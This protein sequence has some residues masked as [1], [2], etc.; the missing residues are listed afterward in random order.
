MGFILMMKMVMKS[1]ARM[2]P[3]ELTYIEPFFK[4]LEPKAIPVVG[5]EWLFRFVCNDKKWSSVIG[6]ITDTS[7]NVL[8]L[9]AKY[10]VFKEM[11]KQHLI[12]FCREC[13]TVIG[14][15]L[16]DG[17]NRPWENICD[18]CISNFD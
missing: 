16:I 10:R 3:I 1:K 5:R 11:E 6:L 18:R 9:R 2:E 17:F 13:N 15:R 4:S 8:K 12:T 7:I 14:S